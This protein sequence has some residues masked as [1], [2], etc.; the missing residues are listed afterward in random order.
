MQTENSALAA[1]DKLTWPID[2]KDLVEKHTDVCRQ[3]LL[4]GIPRNLS[5]FTPS[6]TLLD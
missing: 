5:L 1:N 6:Q 3:I 2:E 4:Q